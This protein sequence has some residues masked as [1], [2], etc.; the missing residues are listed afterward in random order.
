MKEDTNVKTGNDC[1]TIFKARHDVAQL[2]TCGEKRSTDSTA[3]E[4]FNKFRL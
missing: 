1:L 2:D 3:T 4:T